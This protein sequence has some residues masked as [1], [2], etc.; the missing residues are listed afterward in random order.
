MV[1][2]ALSF[3]KMEIAEN[4]KIGDFGDTTQWYSK[5]STYWEGIEASVDGVLGGLPQISGVDIRGSEKFLTSLMGNS[6]AQASLSGVAA[7]CGAG[8]GRITKHMLSKRFSH[9]DV[10]ESDARFLE[11]AKEELTDSKAQHRFILEGL[12]SWVPEPQTYDLIWAQWVLGH[13]TD[14]DLIAF[15]KRCKTGLKP[16]G[17]IVL[18]ENTSKQ[19]RVWDETDSSVT[20]CDAVFQDIFARSGL[21]V[22]KKT[23][24]TGFP[25]GLFPVTMYA[26]R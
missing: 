7:D 1:L 20:R 21:S 10:V 18:K 15:L 17:W 22:H 12:Q 14:D 25:K 19:E 13:L 6:L 3:S 16:D 23:L 8:I 5:A 9:V 24:Q 26:L 11:K 2:P 4:V